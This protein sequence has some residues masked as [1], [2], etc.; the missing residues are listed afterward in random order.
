MARKFRNTCGGRYYVISNP[1]MKN[2]NTGNFTVQ[3]KFIEAF[4]K[5]FLFEW[6]NPKTKEKFNKV[7][8]KEYILQ[9]LRPMPKWFEDEEKR[10]RCIIPCY[11]ISF[12]KI[13]NY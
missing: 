3:K 9:Y 1:I 8:K 6:T 11:L 12:E 4:D 7:I 13:A 2:L 5:D 10:K